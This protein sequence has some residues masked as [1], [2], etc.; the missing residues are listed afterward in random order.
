M[1]TVSVPQLVIRGVIITPAIQHTPADATE[2]IKG[3]YRVT[4]HDFYE[5]E[6]AT[7]ADARAQAAKVADTWEPLVAV[8]LA[9]TGDAADA[10]AGGSDGSA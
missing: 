7:L 2:Q 9:A 1:S 4:F 8:I 10:P 3:A 5:E 6:F